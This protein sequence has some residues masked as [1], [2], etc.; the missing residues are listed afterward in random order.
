MKWDDLP[1]EKTIWLGFNFMKINLGAEMGMN[2]LN[3]GF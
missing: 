2:M 1:C 3:F